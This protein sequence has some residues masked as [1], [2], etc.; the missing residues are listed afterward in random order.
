[1]VND[2]KNITSFRKIQRELLKMGVSI[3]IVERCASMEAI[4]SALESNRDLPIMVAGNNII[5]G[6]TT[7]C[8]SKNNIKVL[9]NLNLK[10]LISLH[11]DGTLVMSTKDED[12]Y[13]DELGAVTE[14][15]SED[16]LFNAKRI[17]LNDGMPYIQAGTSALTYHID[18]GHPDF[19]SSAIDPYYNYEE[20]SARYPRLGK[21]YTKRW[22]K[23][24]NYETLCDQVR[25]EVLEDEEYRRAMAQDYPDD[26]M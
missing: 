5:C 8:L 16:E 24:F 15:R 1:M 9:D 25:E 18:N 17:M 22:G 19:I 21:W 13:V 12:I 14:V 6:D 3:E 26:V 23:D 2:A 11:N 20:M 10:Q 7:I 4:M